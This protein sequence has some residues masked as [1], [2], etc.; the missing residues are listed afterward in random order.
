[1]MTVSSCWEGSEEMFNK[2]FTGIISSTTEPTRLTLTVKSTEI[3][4]IFT[5]SVTTMT[6]TEMTTMTSAGKSNSCSLLWT[7]NS[8]SI[9]TYCIY[10]HN[11]NVIYVSYKQFF[12]SKINPK[13]FCIQINYVNNDNW[14]NRNNIWW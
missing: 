14:D 10:S 13:V 3:S 2:T 11:K 4:T 9:V 12:T 5:T 6:S 7:P 1:M 8:I